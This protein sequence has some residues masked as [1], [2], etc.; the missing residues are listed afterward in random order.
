MECPPS[1][2]SADE[3]EINE[4]WEGD[5]HLKAMFAGMLA[6]ALGWDPDHNVPPALRD[7]LEEAEKALEIANYRSCVVMCRRALEA[8]LKFAF[9][10]LLKRPP[11]DKKGHGL[12][13]NA[14]I[15]EFKK[16]PG[17]PIPMH[18]LHVT[19]SVRIVGNV[20]GAHAEEIKDYKFTRYDAQFALASAHHFVQQY[21]SKID[22]EVS[23][24]YTLTIDL[25]KSG[26]PT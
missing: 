8:L 4:G 7:S 5:P 11:T 13:L 26:D 15:E 6:G 1:F 9:P 22:P 21:F 24:Y 19:D 12:M 20:P 10:R 23:E 25:S 16:A 17:H 18:L 2:H 14:M 3:F